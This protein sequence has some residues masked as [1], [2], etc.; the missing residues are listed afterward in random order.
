MFFLCMWYLPFPKTII[1]ISQ[2]RGDF[3]PPVCPQN[4]VLGLYSVFAE[5]GKLIVSAETVSEI[6]L[7]SGMLVE[8]SIMFPQKYFF[9]K[10]WISISSSFSGKLFEIQ[11]A[12]CEIKNYI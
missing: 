3:L 5:S 8:D 4:Y 7:F 1:W 11:K 2:L 10:S 9:K 6:I 12:P